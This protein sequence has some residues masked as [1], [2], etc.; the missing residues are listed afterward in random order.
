MIDASTLCEFVVNPFPDEKQAR[1]VLATIEGR[2]LTEVDFARG[3]FCFQI[4]LYFLAWLAIS[5]S[6]EVSLKKNAIDELHDQLRAFYSEDRNRSKVKFSDFIIS[7]AEQNHLAAMLREKLNK[8]ED[9]PVDTSGLTTTKLTL[10]DLVGNHRLQEYYDAMA[11]PN[12]HEFYFVAERVLFHY[13]AKQFHSVPVMIVANILLGNYAIATSLVASTAKTQDAVW[14]DRS[15]TDAIPFSPSLPDI[16]TREPLKVYTDGR[17]TLFLVDDVAPLGGGDFVK[18]K[19]ALA[20][21]DGLRN[22]PVCF[23]TLE[24]S[25]LVSNALCVFEM[26]G[27]RSNYGSLPNTN[28]MQEFVNN[29]IKLVKERFALGDLREMSSKPEKRPWWKF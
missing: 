27:S 2:K 29:G 3:V 20:V 14:D 23:I 6:S 16:T 19:Y 26:D 25:A 11:R 17:H 18:Y 1:E 21:F 4:S 13:G 22:L 12:L 15:E 9:I 7:P 24:S 10:F 8:S 5:K 28:Q